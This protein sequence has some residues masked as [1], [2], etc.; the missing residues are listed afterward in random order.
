MP[1]LIQSFATLGLLTALIASPA[2]ADTYRH[3]DELANDIEDKARLLE[4]EVRHY[5]H[6]P[7]YRH[8]VED[9]RAIRKLADHIHDVAHDHGSLSHMESDLR[10]LDRE[11]HHLVSVFDRVERHAAHGHGHIHGDTRHV[12]RLLHYIEVDIHHMQND[13]RSLRRPYH[14]HDRTTL[15]RPPVFAAPPSRC[16][17]DDAYRWGGSG[18]G[19]GISIGSGSSRFTIRW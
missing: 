9:T 12:R 1:L 10:E 17:D 8:L 16:P 14:H 18:F 15:A 11:F 3:I 7:E 4:K 2:L 13:F 5:R 19:R 6:T